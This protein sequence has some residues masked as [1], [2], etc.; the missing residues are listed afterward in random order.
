MPKPTPTQQ[1]CN[2]AN[3]G[4]V[5]MNKEYDGSGYEDPADATEPDTGAPPV[6]SS[7][8]P[9]EAASGSPDFILHCHGDHFEHSSVIFFGG[10]SEVTTF[11]SGTELT[12]EV[13]PSI[14]APAVVPVTIRTGGQASDPVDFTFTAPV[15]RKSKRS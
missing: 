13:N 5:V 14:F 3:Y 6:L 4:V 1:E 10:E 8:S 2:L 15:E 7:I 11:V 12:T 9:G